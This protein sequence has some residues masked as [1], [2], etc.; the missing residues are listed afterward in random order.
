MRR[1]S[2]RML[3]IESP[4]NTYIHKGLPPGPIRMVTRAALDAVPR[5]RTRLPLHVRLSLTSAT[6]ISPS[7]TIVTA[8]TPPSITAP[9]SVAAYADRTSE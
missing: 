6:M 8:S 9:P 1:V 5:L 4:Y 3:D 2:R 7:P